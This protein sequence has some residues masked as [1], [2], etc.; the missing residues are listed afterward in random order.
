MESQNFASTLEK[1]AIEIITPVLEH[2][3]VLSGQYAKACGRDTILGKDMEY[4]MKY[5]AMN[6][7]GNKIGSYFPDIYDEE[8]SDDEEIEVVDEVDEDIQFEPYSGSDVNMLAINDA[9][10]AWE[11]WKPTNP[12][13]KMIK[14]AIDSNEHL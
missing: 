14:N 3:V 1:S 4:C 10:D 9:Y 8:E 2:S 7:V 13:E 6:T 12:S 5:C 11:A